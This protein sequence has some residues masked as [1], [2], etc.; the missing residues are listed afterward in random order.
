MAGLWYFMDILLECAL[1]YKKLFNKKYI[2]KLGRKGKIHL[3]E[4]TF[5][6]VDFHHLAGLKKLD[7]IKVLHRNRALVFKEILKEKITINTIT[8][9]VKFTEIKN[10]LHYLKELETYLDDVKGIYIYDKNKNL[11]SKIPAD[12]LM[13][14]VIDKTEVFYFT[15]RGN[16]SFVG[17]SFFPKDKK[18]Y[19]D[20]QVK[21]VLLEK[22]KVDLITNKTTVLY[23]RE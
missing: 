13:K 12:Y 23:K 5:S 10:R 9:S 3:I 8:K 14:N 21:L 19:T 22:S 18:D 4:L 15:L 6:E 2:F 7:D 11:G 16:G 20:R 1:A 17:I